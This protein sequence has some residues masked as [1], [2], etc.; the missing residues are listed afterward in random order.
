MPFCVPNRPSIDSKQLAKAY[1]KNVRQ[2]PR[3]KAVEKTRIYRKDKGLMA[4]PSA[5]GVGFCIMRKQTYE[6]KLESLLQS[7]VFEKRCNY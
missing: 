1:A 4:V 5:K 3:E 2:I 7:A 6:S